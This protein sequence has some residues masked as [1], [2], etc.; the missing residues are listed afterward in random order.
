MTKA[1]IA[2]RMRRKNTLTRIRSCGEHRVVT[3]EFLSKPDIH[4]N[5]P[6]DRCPF[7]IIGKAKVK[8]MNNKGLRQLARFTPK[9]DSLVYEVYGAQART[10]QCD[11]CEYKF[12]TY[13]VEYPLREREIHIPYCNECG[14]PSVVTQQGNMQ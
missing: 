4:T 14:K 7:C 8:R 6:M 10:R 11:M 12:T 5:E 9:A 3:R 13:E 1:M 2:Q